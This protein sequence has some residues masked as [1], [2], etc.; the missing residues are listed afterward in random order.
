[1]DTVIKKVG[2][3]GAGQMGSG[4]TQVFVEKGFAVVLCDV[5]AKKCD[6][7]KHNIAKG[8]QKLLDRGRICVADLE[9]ALS[10][11]KL[12]DEIEDL[13]D[14]D[15]VVESVSEDEALKK[16]VFKKL[17]RL[18]R[19]DV[20]LSS[21]T[22]SISITSIAAITERPDKVVGLHFM[23]PAPI[24]GGIEIIKGL[25]TSEKTLQI[26]RT[27]A[28]QLNKT[29]I[30]A[31]DRPGFIVNRI[32]FPMLN[33]AMFALYEGVSTKEEIDNGM[34]L[35]CNLPIGPLALADM[36]G[37]DTVLAILNTLYLGFCDTKY[38]PCPLLK[39]FVEAGWLGKKSGKGFFEYL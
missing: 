34:K 15:F 13:L 4:I 8:L 39:E 22:S 32:L 21:N 23:N 18:T 24:M 37:L 29:A 33:E 36:I 31:N 14:V 35:C 16:D 25:L 17:S 11:I 5:D 6:M 7:A 19:D 20:V 38:R 9:K 3:V 12:T 28:S 30:I 10:L 1:M 2:I 27:L 26:I